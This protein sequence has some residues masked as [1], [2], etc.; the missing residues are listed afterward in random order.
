MINKIY[1]GDCVEVMAQF[2]D[3]YVDLVVTSPPYDLLRLYTE[4]YLDF[5]GVINQLYRVVKMGGVVV[6]VVNDSTVGG[7]ETGSSFEQV[8]YFLEV[9]FRLHDTMIWEKS[10]V[11]YPSKGRY[12]QIFDY[13]FVFSKGKPKTFNPICDVPKLWEGSWGKTMTRNKDGTL[14]HRK[15]DNEGKASSGRDDTG[16]YGFKQRTNIW[17]INNGQGFGS[18]D[19]AVIEHPA[20]FPEQL[21]QDHI[22]TWSNKGDLVLD[23]LCGSGTTLKVA[24]INNR[25]YIGIDISPEYCELAKR[26]LDG[27]QL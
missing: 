15:L 11:S 5:E 2:P 27:T 6:W 4:Q 17:K 22:F 20:T 14:S 18:K 8:L 10:G 1:C 12:T 25:A 23:P 21:A 3:D 13:M 9:G 7:S 19:K 26:R 16:K 24:Y